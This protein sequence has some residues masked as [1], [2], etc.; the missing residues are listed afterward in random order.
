VPEVGE[1]MSEMGPKCQKLVQKC[2]EKV[3]KMPEM[4]QKCQKGVKKCQM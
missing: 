2:P 4:G 1:N 3:K